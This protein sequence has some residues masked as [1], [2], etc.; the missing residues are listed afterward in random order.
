MVN[1]VHGRDVLDAN[2]N[3]A[4]INLKCIN[5][6]REEAIAKPVSN[7]IGKRNVAHPAG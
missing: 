5:C 7:K 6:R 4:A 3:K 2:I 1:V